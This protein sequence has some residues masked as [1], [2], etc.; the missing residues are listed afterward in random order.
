MTTKKHAA[1]L[2]MTL[3]ALTGLLKAQMSTTIQ[4]QVPFEFVTNGETMP[5][6][7]CKVDVVVS[8]GQTLLWIRSGKQY[9]FAL[10]I[11]DESSKASKR[12][13]LV[14]HRYGDQYFLASIRRAGRINY[15]LPASGLEGE[16]RARNVTEEVF[17]LLASVE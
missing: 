8:N 15:E 10:P 5:S 9:I 7:E 3:V 1:L 13:A 4:A 2:L 12:T 16:L 6:G 17:T 11:L 14:F